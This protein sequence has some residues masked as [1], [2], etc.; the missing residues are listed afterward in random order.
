[1]TEVGQ[2]ER[3]RRPGYTESFTDR[4]RVDAFRAGFDQQPE[5]A[6]ARLVPKRREDF[7]GIQYFHI[8]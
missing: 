2:V 7:G 8:C 4:A 3:Q 5:D 6:E 1:M